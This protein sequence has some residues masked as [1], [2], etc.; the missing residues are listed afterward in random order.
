ML[1]YKYRVWWAGGGS[2]ADH[3][4]KVEEVGPFIELTSLFHTFFFVN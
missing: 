1:N 3:E 4:A 2:R